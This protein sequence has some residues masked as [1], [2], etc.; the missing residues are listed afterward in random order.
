MF[1]QRDVQP[2]S[3]E[4]ILKGLAKVTQNVISLLTSCDTRIDSSKVF[5]VLSLSRSNTVKDKEH[6]TSP[7]VTQPT[8]MLLIVRVNDLSVPQ[9][10]HVQHI[11]VTHMPGA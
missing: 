11:K 5:T 2:K 4:E 8:S 6:Q 7:R 10:I 1:T 3:S 9:C